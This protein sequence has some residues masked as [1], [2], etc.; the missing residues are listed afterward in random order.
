M[1]EI[2]FVNSRFIHL[3]FL[4]FIFCFKE[5][6]Q[7]EANSSRVCTYK[8]DLKLMNKKQILCKLVLYIFRNFY[9]DN[10]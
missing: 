7:G 8:F 4:K 2:F 9:S 6:T 5:L 10:V 3:F 1:A